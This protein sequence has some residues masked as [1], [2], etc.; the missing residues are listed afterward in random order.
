[1]TVR[2]PTLRDKRRYILVRVYPPATPIDQKELYYVVSD[3]VTS[4]WGDAMA[5]VIVQAVVCADGDYVVIRC[6]RGT[7]RELSIALSTIT[8]YRDTKIALRIIAASGTI[9]SLRDRMKA[10][11]ES[12]TAGVAEAPAA[13]CRFGGKEY[14]VAHCDGQKIDVIEKGFKNTHRLFLTKE[15]LEEP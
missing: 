11:P 14:L 9:D 7:E 5:A 4:L 13:E 2:P 12:G 8:M 15:D 10:P 3:A 6:R 1:M